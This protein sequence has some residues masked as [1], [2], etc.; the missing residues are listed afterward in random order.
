[1]NMLKLTGLMAAAVFVIAGAA[2]ADIPI[3]A[4][5]KIEAVA[6]VDGTLTE[7]EITRNNNYQAWLDEE[8]CK[9][10][11]TT[12][13]RV[14][15]TRECHTRREWEQIRDANISLLNDWTKSTAANSN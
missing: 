9:R 14:R 6:E 11:P 10:R 7:E 3:K 12:G 1:M 13:S 4:E 8:V 5:P 2:S 15:A